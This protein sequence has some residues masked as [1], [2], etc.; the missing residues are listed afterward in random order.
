MKSYSK[1]IHFHSRKSIW[2]SRPQCV[3]RVLWRHRALGTRSQLALS[4][5]ASDCPT[6]VLPD[7][8]KPDLN[9]L[10][11]SLNGTYYGMVLYLCVSAVWFVHIKG[12]LSEFGIS[13]CAEGS[14]NI[15]TWFSSFISDSVTLDVLLQND[16]N[17]GEVINGTD[18]RPNA[19]ILVW[20]TCAS[21]LSGWV[22]YKQLELTLAYPSRLASCCGFVHTKRCLS[23][24]HND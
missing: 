4:D 22:L 23:C 8:Q 19:S 10:R 7:N 16:G 15:S 24:V 1:N 20:P 9:Y 14:K 5:L 13:M 17:L 21:A 12:R 11:P 3:N 6:V 18:V 2:K